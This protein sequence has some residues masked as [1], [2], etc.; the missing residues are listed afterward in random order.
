M[1]LQ[2]IRVLDLSRLLPAAY[3]TQL[4]VDMGADV[5]KVEE[6]TSGDY[7]RSMEPTGP[8]GQNALFDSVNRGKR[9]LSLDLKEPA[10]RETFYALL[11]HADVVFESFRP[12][13]A[14]RLGV[15]YDTLAAETDD[16][17]YCSLTGYG[18]TGPYRDRPGHDV[19]YLGYTG[20]LDM[21][22]GDESEPPE[23]PGVPIADMAS[24]V[25]AALTIVGGILTREL[26]NG[27]SQYYD[28]SMMDSVLSMSHPV[29]VHAARGEEPRPG[30]TRYTGQ[31]PS[32]GIYE[33]SDG[34]YVSLVS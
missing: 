4:L 5:I 3:A 28:V 2:R 21:T 31:F 32:Y 14:E 10:G 30:E 17:I 20:F 25:F 8:A 16:L 29:S 19:N 6:P 24:G 13:V 23:I 26:G 27:W 33:T 1:D 9:S 22:R 18:E 15:D 7:L 11:D 34:R 12:G